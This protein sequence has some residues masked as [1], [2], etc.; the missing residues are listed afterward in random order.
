MGNSKK[1]EKEK[2]PIRLRWKK[3]ANGNRSAYLD[4]YSKGKRT[5][6]FLKGYYLVPEVNKAAKE[7]NKEVRR[8]AVAIKS[9]R[10]RELADGY[11]LKKSGSDENL[12]TYIEMIIGKKGKTTKINY[13]TFLGHIKKYSGTDAKFSKVDKAYCSG[14]I[15]YLASVKKK[16]GKALNVNSQAEYLVKLRYVL[17]AAV[18]D[19]FLQRNPMEQISRE[20]R[21]KTIEAEVKYLSV[22]EVKKLK[23]TAYLP[24][25]DVRSAFLFSCFVGLRFSD[26]K[27]LT[28]GKIKADRDGNPIITYRQEKTQKQEYLPVSKEAMAYIPERGA[29][30]DDDLVFDLNHAS[31]AKYHLEK[32]AKLAGVDKKISF[33]VARHTCATLLLSQ[34]APIEVVQKILGHSDI[35][36]TQRYAKIVAKSVRA[37]V[38]LLDGITD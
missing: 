8:K 9:Q 35:R 36:T 12:I 30:K 19:G 28:W 18:R 21:P 34:G 33:H 31:T 22:D 25:Q 16:D 11:G 4:H 6:E 1:D 13:G 29:A 14:F 38:S 23:N 17:S 7:E 32:W 26:T 20:N 5:Y 24:Y 2:E 10:I 3:L 15:N 37:A 27:A